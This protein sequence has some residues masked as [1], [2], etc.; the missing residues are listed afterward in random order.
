MKNLPLAISCILIFSTVLHGQN[1]D[2]IK[3]DLERDYDI[4]LTLRQ[5]VFRTIKKFGPKSK[6]VDSL[7][8]LILRFDRTALERA[9]YVIDTYG[10][11]GKSQIGSVA[12]QTLFLMV[13][14]AENP[15]VRKKYFPMLEK[16]AKA[17]QSS[18]SDLAS[19]QDRML[20]D[21]GKKQLYGT[22]RTLKG[23]VYPVEDLEHLNQRR[24]E[25][26]L[27]RIRKKEL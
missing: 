3:S 13:Q 20:V 24:R 15:Q 6:Q 4:S 5:S 2:T 9:L 25:V 27:K 10:W 14:H 1:Y 11:L 7:N 12:N 26:G 19:M 17:G 16:S 22:Q 21:A 8:S 18:M 23:K